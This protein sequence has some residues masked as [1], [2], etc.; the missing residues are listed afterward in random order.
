MPTQKGHTRAIAASKVQGT[1]VYNTAGES[2]GQVEDLV[3][4]KTSNNIMFAVLGFGG[5]LGMGEKYHPIPWSVLTY[6][7]DKGGYI[8]PYSKD[9]LK[10]APAYDIN[11]LTKHDGQIR[12]QSF[13][14]YKVERYWE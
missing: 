14:Y 1:P 2:I 13:S 7:E 8:V 5:F 9:V 6:D 12:D 4:D 3:L 10:N 11:D